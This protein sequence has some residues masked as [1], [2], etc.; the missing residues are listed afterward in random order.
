MTMTKRRETGNEQPTG[1][2]P[3]LSRAE[4]GRAGQSRTA[5]C[6]AARWV[7]TALHSLHLHLASAGSACSACSPRL[8]EENHTRASSPQFFSRLPLCWI[9]PDTSSSLLFPPNPTKHFLSRTKQVVLLLRIATTAPTLSSTFVQRSI[10]FT[11]VLRLMYCTLTRLASCGPQWLSSRAQAS[12][13]RTN[14]TALAT[15]P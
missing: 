3:E 7:G 10:I 13:P 2:W 12:S 8:H 14:R 9:R 4:Q 5:Q 6:S 11:F 1:S 15:W